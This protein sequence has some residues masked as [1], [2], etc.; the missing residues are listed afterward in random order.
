[1][2]FIS[3]GHNSRSHKIAQDPGA[4]NKQGIKEGDLTIEFRDIVC[5]ELDRLGVKY[6]KDSDE[7]SLKM[8][9]DR[10]KTGTGSV[11]IEYHFDSSTNETATGTTALVADKATINS[12]SFAKEIV[13]ST[14][15][16]LGVKNRGVE[17]ESQSHRCRLGL[18]RENGIVTLSELGFITNDS[19]LEKY[20][21][22]KAIL[23]RSHAL[24]IQK[25]ENLVS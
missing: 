24:I 18:M 22:G 1:M 9:L 7:E 15:S 3:A 2:I 8:Y 21:K 23:A 25:Y 17:P 11:V 6:T 19:D 13:D 5:T 14:S 20:N 10:I 12:L 16:L 4:V